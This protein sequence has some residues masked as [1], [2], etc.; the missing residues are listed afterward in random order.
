MSLNILWISYSFFLF[1]FSGSTNVTIWKL[2]VDV[3]C[4][5]VVMKTWC[6]KETCRNQGTR[7]AISNW[8]V[9]SAKRRSIH[10]IW[11]T[12]S[13]APRHNI[14]LITRNKQRCKKNL[15][16]KFKCFK[17][18]IMHQYLIDKSS[19]CFF[20]WSSTHWLKNIALH[21]ANKPYFITN[22]IITT[23]V[24]KV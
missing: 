19:K 8:C 16:L 10:C 2:V 18:N 6:T 3:D 5:K 1:F 21:W 20:V 9:K 23:L 11:S 24:L 14:W 13:I 17:G 15:Y 12:W 4:M 7:N 22:F